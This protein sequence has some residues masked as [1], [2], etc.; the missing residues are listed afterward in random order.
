MLWLLSLIASAAGVAAFGTAV[1]AC[2]GAQSRSNKAA[3]L[4]MLLLV[5]GA[6]ARPRPHQWM[7]TT[8]YTGGTAGLVLGS[9]AAFAA[10]ALGYWALHQRGVPDAL[11]RRLF[12]AEAEDSSQDS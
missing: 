10:G 5:L 6:L 9:L 8:G 11:G 12:G 3:L 4:G 2:F 1:D 7:R